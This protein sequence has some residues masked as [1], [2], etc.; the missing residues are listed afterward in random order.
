MLLLKVISAASTNM[1]ACLFSKADRESNK[2]LKHR[3]TLSKFTLQT[4][5]QNP[6]EN[7]NR[8]GNVT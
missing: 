6:M 4:A 3:H 8:K 1:G 2:L 5:K 7:I